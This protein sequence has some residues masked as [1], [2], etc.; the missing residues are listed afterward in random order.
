[1]GIM[2]NSYWNVYWDLFFFFFFFWFSPSFT[3]SRSLW[4]LSVGKYLRA[5][6]PHIVCQ[7][8]N[9]TQHNTNT[10]H[11]FLSYSFNLCFSFL[12][13]RCFVACFKFLQ[14][15][16]T[17]ACYCV[18]FVLCFL[19]PFVLWWKWKPLT[20]SKRR[21]IMPNGVW[22]RRRTRVVWERRLILQRP[23][24]RWRKLLLCSGVVTG[25]HPFTVILRVW[26]LVLRYTHSLFNWFMALPQNST[27]Q[28]E[29]LS[30]RCFRL[31][32]HSSVEKGRTFVD[33]ILKG[34]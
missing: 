20:W 12:T 11:S 15:G 8:H 32:L 31:L 7:R 2:G 10:F 30:F 26:L 28:G 6:R 17:R 27:P 16:R 22:R 5:T 29:M 4:F 21:Q 24:N 3:H 18:C 1:M 9:T 14:Q 34:F 33:G 23:L 13:S 19:V 25:N